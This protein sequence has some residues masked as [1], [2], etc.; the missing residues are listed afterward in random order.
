METDTR[1]IEKAHCNECLHETKHFVIAERV[2]SGKEPADPYDPYCK[3]EIRWST[4]Y[5]MLECCGCENV[6]LRREFYFSELDEIEEE[7]Y[8]PQI[9]RMMPKWHEQLPEEW[10]DLLKEVYAALHA[11]SRRLALMGAR[12]LVDMYMTVQLG[13]IGGFAQKIKQLDDNGLISKPNKAFLEAALEAGHAAA[14]RGHKPKINE[15]NQVIDIVE[16]LL[17]SHVLTKVGESLKA[18]T[19]SRN[20]NGT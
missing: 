16:N 6:S 9:S 20:T 14:H 1:K 8:P 19:P 4:T 10:Q 13:D 18:K 7:F 5:T 12:A 3:D 17:Q 2:I 15:V 11:D